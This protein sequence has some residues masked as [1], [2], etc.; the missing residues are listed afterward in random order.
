MHLKLINIKTAP[1]PIIRVGCRIDRKPL[2]AII[3]YR[4]VVVVIASAICVNASHVL[5]D[6]ILFSTKLKNVRTPT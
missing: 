2:K 4:L 6:V 1:R 5:S 3:N